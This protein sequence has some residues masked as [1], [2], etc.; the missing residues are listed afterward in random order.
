MQGCQEGCNV[1]ILSMRMELVCYLSLETGM[2]GCQEGCNVDILSMR[3]ELVCYLSLETGMQGSKKGVL[4]RECEDAFL[5][6]GAV[7]IVVLDNHVLLQ[8]L[9]CEHLLRTLPL[10]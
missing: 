3:M 9:H 2:R 6:H 5:R 8:H 1:D 10:R 7:N 4:G